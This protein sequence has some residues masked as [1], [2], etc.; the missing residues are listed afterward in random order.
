KAGESALLGAMLGNGTTSISKDDFNEEVDFLGAN[1]SFGAS[2]A[3]ASSLT[4]YSS[5]ILELMA[6]A[7]IN[8]LLTEE[9]FQKEKDKLLEGLKSSEKSVDAIAGRVGNALS[10]G[11]N[12]PYGEITSEETVNNVT[13]GDVVAFY[14]KYFNPNNAYLVVIGDV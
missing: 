12:H 7:V 3:Y 6:D 8:P 2:S 5:R 9:E 11:K 13:F 1:I 10:Y 14:D 4:Q